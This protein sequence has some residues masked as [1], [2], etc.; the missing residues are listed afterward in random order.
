M[1]YLDRYF[2][3]CLPLV[4]PMAGFGPLKMIMTMLSLIL[5]EFWTL[6]CPLIEFI[7]GELVDVEVLTQMLRPG[8]Y[9]E[10][11]MYRT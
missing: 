5:M 2:R 7:R 10:L 9:V 1:F 4:I 8:S 11:I 3:C 6:G